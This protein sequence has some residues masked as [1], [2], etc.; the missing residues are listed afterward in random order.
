MLTEA[1]IINKSE[2]FW[3]QTPARRSLT[4]VFRH[5]LMMLP[6]ERQRVKEKKVRTEEE[7]ISFFF[8]IKLKLALTMFPCRA[9]FH[10][11]LN[12]LIF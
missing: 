3:C 1:E 6:P 12:E 4:G 10:I 9:T 7:T 8:R 11:C 2:H 5:P